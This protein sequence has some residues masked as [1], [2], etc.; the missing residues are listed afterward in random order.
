MPIYAI[1]FIVRWLHTTWLIYKWRLKY[2]V[3]ICNLT[4]SRQ[5][6]VVRNYNRRI[7]FYII[8]YIK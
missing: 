7:N 6:N 3:I 4:I 8:F 5:H 1:Q 2:S